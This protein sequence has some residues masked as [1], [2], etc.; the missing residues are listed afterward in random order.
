MKRFLP[1]TEKN[2]DSISE[3][4]YQ[5]QFFVF[6]FFFLHLAINFMRIIIHNNNSTRCNRIN[7]Y[8]VILIT[9]DFCHYRL[10]SQNGLVQVCYNFLKIALIL[11][12]EGKEMMR[13]LQGLLLLLKISKKISFFLKRDT[14]LWNW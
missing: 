14:F 10:F 9:V 3:I 5:S 12:W 11:R 2:T 6:C 13:K 4:N 8:N 1:V 7:Y